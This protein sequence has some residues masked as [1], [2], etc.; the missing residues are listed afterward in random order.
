MDKGGVLLAVGDFSRMAALTA[1]DEVD[2]LRIGV[3]QRVLVTGNAFRDLRLRGA[4]SRVSSQPLPKVRG[5]VQFE[6]EVTLDPLEPEQRERLRTGMSSRLDIVVYRKEAALLVPIKAVSKR[7]GT[8][9]LRV[10]DRETR[11][12][13]EREV[14]IGPTTLDSVEIVAGLSVGEQIVLPAN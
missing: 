12:V 13:R 14:E 1:V 7:G 2:V 5:V 8:H 6:V 11:E 9:R 3:G 4:V 10:M